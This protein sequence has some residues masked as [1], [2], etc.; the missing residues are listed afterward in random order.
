M[1]SEIFNEQISFN[2]R[3]IVLS[4]YMRVL[5]N[6]FENHLLNKYAEYKPIINYTMSF[7]ELI[8]N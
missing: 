3:V 6:C 5:I 2:Y 4:A 8:L 7:E 1:D